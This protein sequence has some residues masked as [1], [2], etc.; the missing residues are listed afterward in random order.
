MKKLKKV[1]PYIIIR[2][3]DNTPGCP[4]I[5][6]CPKRLF[7]YD[8]KL[9]KL[10]LENLDDCIG[11]GICEVECEHEAVELIE[12]ANN[13]RIDELK[14][15]DENYIL[16]KSKNLINNYGGV[17]P[18]KI[19]NEK[20]K[21]ITQKEISKNLNG[22]IF[23]YGKWQDESYIGYSILEELEDKFE[24]I[25][26]LNAEEFGKDSVEELPGFWIVKNGV[27][28][29]KYNINNIFYVVG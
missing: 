5:E 18:K 21:K 1:V 22:L 4:V 26:L 7:Y 14:D 16:E 19:D 28:E 24:N 9:K 15:M 10:L 17:L 29:G 13:K 12:I 3:C 2:N 20:Y 25:Y 23:V 11:C 8:F 27:I 6:A